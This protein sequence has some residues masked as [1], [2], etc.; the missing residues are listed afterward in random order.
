MGLLNSK[1][2]KNYEEIPDNK[3]FR[4]AIFFAKNRGKQFFLTQENAK[5]R[6]DQVLE[7]LIV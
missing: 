1:S 7:R 2:N 5:I 4:I 3:Y 6:K